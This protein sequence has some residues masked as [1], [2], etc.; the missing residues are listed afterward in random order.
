[1]GDYDLW[2][3]TNPAD[4]EQE[5][6][7]SWVEANEDRLDGLSDEAIEALYEDEQY[8]AYDDY[9]VPSEDD[10]EYDRDGGEDYLDY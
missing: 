4:V 7:E 2:L 10:Y 6:F 9:Y 8:D 1:M 3:S 5:R